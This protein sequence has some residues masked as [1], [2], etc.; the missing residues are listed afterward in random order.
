MAIKKMNFTM[1]QEEF[2]AIL[3]TRLE[4]LNPALAAANRQLSPWNG[5]LDIIAA[6]DETKKCP[7]CG[8]IKSAIEFPAPTK[9]YNPKLSAAMNMN[10]YCY[11]CVYADAINKLK[12]HFEEY[13]NNPVKFTCYGRKAECFKFGWITLGNCFCGKPAEQWHHLNYARPHEGIGYCIEHHTEVH[14]LM[15]ALYLETGFA[16]FHHIV[17]YFKGIGNLDRSYV[18]RDYY[19][20]EILNQPAPL[21]IEEKEKLKNMKFRQKVLSDCRATVRSR[22]RKKK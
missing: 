7:H 2:N 22:P 9:R 6:S 1:T 15:K 20:D 3:D 11:E 8:G 17:R 12:F 18:V 14:N 19:A 13:G 16:P 10:T 5:N 21:L 4:S